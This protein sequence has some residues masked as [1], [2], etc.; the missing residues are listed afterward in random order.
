MELLFTLLSFILI[1]II[2]AFL[3][4]RLAKKVRKEEADNQKNNKVCLQKSIII[5]LL[6]CCII[7]TILSLLLCIFSNDISKSS[8]FNF[9]SVS[10]PLLIVCICL[11]FL[12]LLINKKVYYFEEFFVYIHFFKKKIIYYKDITKIERNKF[13][14]LVIETNNSR[15]LLFNAMLGLEKFENTAK[16]KVY[17]NN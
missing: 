10:I 7:I 2:L 12:I 8:G 15:I 5:F 13:K 11:D 16:E 17:K 6:V 4:P 1:E 3:L 14:N 9:Y